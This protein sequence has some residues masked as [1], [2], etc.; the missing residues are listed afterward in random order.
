MASDSRRQKE[1]QGGTLAFLF[2][3]P[4][5]IRDSNVHLWFNLLIDKSWN[6]TLFFYQNH[7]QLF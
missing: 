6:F 4:S 2:V 5:S 7:C 1:R 3:I